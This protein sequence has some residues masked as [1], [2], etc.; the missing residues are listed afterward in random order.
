MIAA[1]PFNFRSKSMWKKLLSRI[2]VLA[3]LLALL[4]AQPVAVA[5]EA[6]APDSVTAY[7]TVSLQD[8]GSLSFA[9]A[10]DGSSMAAK[11]VEVSD[12]DNDGLLTLYDMLCC[13]HEQFAPGGMS[14]FVT[15][16][17]T[18]NAVTAKEIW[19]REDSF[20]L[21]LTRGQSTTA[22]SLTNLK[23]NNVNLL[24]SEDSHLYAVQGNK[25]DFFSNTNATLPA[26][27][28]L[29]N[30]PHLTVLANQQFTVKMYTFDSS[31]TAPP[32]IV[33]AAKNRE[34]VYVK[35]GSE[36]V[37]SAGS[38][39]TQGKLDLTL[40]EPGEYLLYS[41][42]TDGQTGSAACIVQVVEDALEID[43]LHLS[44]SETGDNLITGFDAETKEYT[45]TIPD[46][47]SELYCQASVDD[48]GCNIRMYV[49]E[50]PSNFFDINTD[51]LKTLNLPD[52]QKITLFLN[53]RHLKEAGNDPISTEYVIYIQRQVQ[54]TG[55]ETSGALLSDADL[56]TGALDVYVAHDATE[57]TL[58]PTAA[59]G[60]IIT[61]NEQ[62]V[63]S[64][65]TATITLDSSGT[66]TATVNVH[67][68]AE[69][70]IDRS[71]T[72]TF[73]TAGSEAVPIF[74]EQPA[75]IQEYFVGDDEIESA[76]GGTISYVKDLT[77]YADAGGEV[78]YQWYSNTTDSAEDATLLEDETGRSYTPSV[79][80]SGE[81]YYY[82]VASCGEESTI[83]DMAHVIV[84]DMPT[85]DWA[86]DLEIPELPADKSEL[87]GGHTEGFYYKKGDTDVTPLRAT[88]NLPDSL[89]DR[90]DVVVSSF[91][92]N[93]PAAVGDSFTEE[94]Y[95]T[96]ATWA[97]FGGCEYKVIARLDVPWREYDVNISCDTGI[98]VY[99]DQAENTL[100]PEVASSAWPN[101]DG[102]E[103]SPWELTSQE[104]LV[105]LAAFVKQGYS[106]SGAYFLM[107]QDISLD[108]TW[109]SIGTGDSS[110]GDGWSPF[111]G[112]LDGG[113][114]TL[115]YAEG[116]D[117]PLFG[118]VREASVKNLAIYAPYMKNY[119]LVSNY[120]V[121]YGDDGLYGVGVGGSYAAGCPDTIDITNVTIKS[122][123]VIEQS[124]FIG[125]FASGGNTVNILNCT[126]E[127]NVK[128]GWNLTENCSAENHNIGSF[129]GLFN[130]TISNC[131][132]YADVYGS[133]FVGGIAGDKGQSMGYFEIDNCAFL[134][135]VNASGNC[136]GGIAGSGYNAGSAPNTPGST[137]RNCYVSGDITGGNYVGGILGM[138][139]QIQAWNTSYI[140]NN[141]FY[142]T[143]R[144]T[145]ENGT[146]GGIIG[147]LNSLNSNNFIEN[148]YSVEGCGAEKA[149]GY[150]E[151]LDTSAT[152]PA[153]GS[154]TVFNTADK[155][156]QIRGV[157]KR[158]LNRSDDPL[159]A[160][161][162]KLGAVKT[163][164]QF[165]DGTVAQ[166]LNASESSLKNW[167]TSENGPVHSRE[168][169][170]YKLSISGN[171]QTSYV[172]GENLNLSG[173]VFTA[174]RSDNLTFDVPL[175]EIEISGYDKN[176]RGVQTLT[177]KYGLVTCE[178]TVTV[179]KAEN[180]DPTKNVITVYF[181]LMGDDNHNWADDYIPEEGEAH[182]LQYGG[183]KTWISNA[184]YTVDQNATVADLLD[185]I[186]EK[187]GVVFD[188]PTG[189]YVESV[190]YNGI[191]L[192][193]FDNGNLSG[194]MYTLN[195]T[196]PLYGVSEQFLE[197]GDRIVWHYTDDY[198]KEEGSEHWVTGGTT[199]GGTSGTDE[200]SPVLEPEVS[201]DKNGNAT[202]TIPSKDLAEAIES[203][204]E[205]GTQS[206]V[207][208]PQVSGNAT[209]LTVTIPK[210]SVT[211]ILDETKAGLSIECDLGE[212]ELPQDALSAIVKAA[213][214]SDITVT[215]AVGDS[216]DAVKLLEGQKDVT[217]ETM[218]DA[219]V[220]VVTITS[221]E[222]YITAFDGRQITITLPVGGEAF[223]EGKNY[224]VYQISDDGTVERLAGECI[225]QGKKFFV[226]VTTTH[227]NTFV[228]LPVKTVELPFTDVQ[229][230]DWFYNA[231]SC[232]YVNGL[233]NGTSN[234][235]FSPNDSM[236]RA[237]LATVLYRM[238]GEP[239]GV[240]ENAPFDD[241]AMDSWYTDAVAW[242]NENGIVAGYGNGLFGGNDS[243]TR[244]QLVVM[245]Y[246]YAKFMKHDTAAAGDLSAFTDAGDAS[247]WAVEALRWAY[248]EGLITGRTATTIVPQGTATRAEV[249]TLLMR[250]GGDL[251]E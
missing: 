225:K 182:T 19:G 143:V 246:R 117:Q 125:G 194:W 73:H 213:G 232:A 241:M 161:A 101:G 137:I 178:F 158:N 40:T 216:E 2:M 60:D 20:S 24:I 173:A 142:G 23:M 118:Y 179:L 154:T 104:D 95:F 243:I 54:L 41:V 155:L 13:A 159:G 119:G 22:K 170:V 116:T 160:D 203:A 251:A 190:T 200:N 37:V 214:S 156:P 103:L 215:I 44:L 171:Y 92:W 83:S 153:P 14:D 9:Q 210:S 78:T 17:G 11:A 74:R 87:F 61:V 189:N 111:S 38:T 242:A 34:V 163:L 188:N 120:A 149:I 99:V 94:P 206:I 112:T 219:S 93:V 109:V 105:E 237:M 130:G 126:V 70:Y 198:T 244:E 55:L 176:T 26:I 64:G 48:A 32:Q 50:V 247:D 52:G 195:E 185:L 249:A 184:A 96:P 79:E 139:F 136:V 239:A 191:T 207:I 211:D 236:T 71:Y 80:T 141:C 235:T 240:G 181:K 123:S 226:K 33:A 36:T 57:A 7:L 209:S 202:V 192:G 39:N 84:H 62:A 46:G 107:T 31:K 122:G 16:S 25:T 148:N 128:I 115:S 100:S 231:V 51:T 157:S 175:D 113:G 131:V 76:M 6:T 4:P 201:V 127:D 91:Y 221:G 135:T 228:V 224:V 86:D 132:S 164:E 28:A 88:L 134:G 174:S 183:L 18:N 89:A 1:P 129:G 106:F 124:G 10:R 233:F 144:A 82:C 150:I 133:N 49:T 75:E 220:A 205:N 248:A 30:I 196:H 212:I 186:A 230:T 45:I 151:Y 110:K 146:V 197:D 165:K 187:Y 245:L 81:W 168:P 69:G 138:E 218:K 166:L 59:D 12:L 199:G 66:T 97:S 85:L 77:V 223:E 140:Q 177:A 217:E 172:I 169:I 42:P 56:T 90:D 204:S 180:S 167:I 114:H 68:D 3:M 8:E 67:R 102:T 222:K 152:V 58:T 229:E 121:D 234:T 63:S 29:K 145:E 53:D 35:S 65:D 108:D 147:R 162:D 227:L 98:Y 193:E 250:F 15:I 27:Q 5:A 72:V 238:A 43:R 47:T 21:F 208:T